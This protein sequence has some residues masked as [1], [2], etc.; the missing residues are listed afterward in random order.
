MRWHLIGLAAATLLLPTAIASAQI[1]TATVSGTVVDESKAALPGA[2]IVASDLE[3]GRK[4]ETVSDAR[5]A[6]QLPPLPPGTTSLWAK[7]R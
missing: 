2:T 4:Y 1:S 5:G 7:P 6:Y 3:T